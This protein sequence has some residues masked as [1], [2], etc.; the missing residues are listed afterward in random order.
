MKAGSWY[1]SSRQAAEASRDNFTENTSRSFPY[2]QLRTICEHQSLIDYTMLLNH[3]QRPCVLCPVWLHPLKVYKIKTPSSRKS[4]MLWGGRRGCRSGQTVSQQLR[5]R[6]WATSH[7]SVSTERKMCCVH[8]LALPCI[9][10]VS[11]Y[12]DSIT[13]ISNLLF[14]SSRT[15]NAPQQ[16]YKYSHELLFAGAASPPAAQTCIADDWK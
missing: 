1:N 15:K 2:T 3:L 11:H 14:Y 5:W 7:I 8:L 12:H 4:W 10:V 16:N 6:L 9:Y 13:G